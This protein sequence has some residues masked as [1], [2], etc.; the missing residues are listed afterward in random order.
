MT[1]T[2]DYGKLKR[3]SRNKHSWLDTIDGDE[4][5]P[6]DYSKIEVHGYIPLKSKEPVLSEGTEIF[7]GIV[8]VVILWLV[9]FL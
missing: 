8:F 6:R 5:K 9:F 3:N 7:I 4:V 2:H 1:S